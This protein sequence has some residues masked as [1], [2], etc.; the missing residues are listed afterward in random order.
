MPFLFFR[1]SETGAFP[2]SRTIGST[3][4]KSVGRI[5]CRMSKSREYADEIGLPLKR[6]RIGLRHRQLRHPLQRRH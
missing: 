4:I 5:Q 2:A 6:S 3:E 1:Q